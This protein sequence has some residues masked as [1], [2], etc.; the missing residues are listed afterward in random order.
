LKLCI[1][2]QTPPVKFKLN[3]AELLDKY[4]IL[5]EPLDLATLERGVDYD[6]SPGGVTAMMLPL[7]EEMMKSGFA[8]DPAWVSLGINYPPEVKMGGVSLSHVE[9][10]DSQ[11][12]GYAGFKET[13]WSLIHGLKDRP[14]TT[15]EYQAYV[16]YNWVNANKLLEFVAKADA[17]YVQD[18]QLLLTGQMIGVSAPAVLRWHVP[19]KPEILGKMHRF[20]LKAMEG[21]DAVVVST[22]RDLDGLKR[23]SY[24]GKAYQIYPYVDPTVWPPPPDSSVNSLKDRIGLGDSKAFLIVARMDPMKCQDLAIRALARLKGRLDAKL[25][26]IGNGSFSSSKTGG[27]GHDKGTRWKAHLREVANEAGV[28]EKVVFLGYASELDVKAAYSLCTAVVVPSAIEG[29]GITT[30]EGWVN[31]KPV[32]VSK[33]AG[34]SELVLEGENGYTFD[35]SDDGALAEAMLRAAGADVDSMGGRGYEAAKACFV[36]E[37]SRRVRAVLEDTVSEF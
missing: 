13:L 22:K 23:S 16:R 10:E 14:Y 30:L 11:L 2:T 15:E 29:F 7:L 3:Y 31:R 28:T 26:L 20:V 21:F 27:L 4:G 18:F 17:F 9:L 8:N 37:A 34:S 32:V 35:P 1:D 36:D 24:N 19:F 5:D 6:Y 25:L 33:G 12:R